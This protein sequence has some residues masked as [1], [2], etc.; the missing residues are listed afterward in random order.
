MYHHYV[1]ALLQEGFREEAVR[2]IKLYWGG[3]VENGA[4]TFWEVYYPED[5]TFSPYGDEM[6]NSYCHAWSCTPCYL[7]RK[8]GIA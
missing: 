1:E 6:I 8:Y 3:M 4:D 7:F 5:V 2:I